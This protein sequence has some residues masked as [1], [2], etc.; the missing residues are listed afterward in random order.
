[1]KL[2]IKPLLL[3]VATI[4]LTVGCAATAADT[5]HS[6]PAMGHQSSAGM[7]LATPSGMTLYTFDRDRKGASNCS[8][9]CTQ[10]WPPFAASANAHATGGYDMIKRSD[11]SMQWT[12]DGKPLYTFAGDRAPGDAN[13]NGIGGVWHV[14]PAGG[15][16]NGSSS[17]SQDSGSG[18]GTYGGSNSGGGSW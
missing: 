14:V 6:G 12:Y 9:S 16:D 3:A 8:S 1:M 17:G 7:V 10:N 11:G 15:M 18:K 2:A 13:G 5:Q 4:S